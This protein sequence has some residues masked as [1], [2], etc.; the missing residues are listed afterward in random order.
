MIDGIR[1]VGLVPVRGGS[2]SIPHKNR[3]LLGGKPLMVW[4]IETALAT[5]EIDRVIV[6]TEDPILSAIGIKHGA[7]V[8][9]RHQKFAT[10]S[11]LVVDVI[12]DFWTSISEEGELAQ[13]LV[14]LEATSPFRTPE[15][16]SRC[17]KRL[18]NDNLDSVATFHKA[19]VNPE[20]TWKIINDK[21]TPFIEG[22]IP[23]QPRQALTDAYQLDGAVYAF[24]PDRLPKDAQGILFGNVGAELILDDILVDIDSQEDLELANAILKTR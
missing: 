17:L 13:I 19:S 3:Q 7:E 23:W 24:Y 18:V 8:Y 16:I 12:R 9:P 1:V 4:P 2:K 5:L 15:M 11:A 21:P 6:S 20:R 10:D 14:L 22:A